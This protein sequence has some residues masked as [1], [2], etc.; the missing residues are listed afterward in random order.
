[1]I[2]LKKLWRQ[3]IVKKWEYQPVFLLSSFIITTLIGILGCIITYSNFGNSGVFGMI[4][5]QLLVAPLGGGILYGVIIY[6]FLGSILG[7][8][9]LDSG[10]GGVGYAHAFGNIALI[11]IINIHGY[12]EVVPQYIDR[13][14]VAG[15]S[16][17]LLG[18]VLLTYV[19]NSAVDAYDLAR[20]RRIEENNR[21]N[22]IKSE[23][24]NW[25]KD[26][27]QKIKNL[28]QTT[29]NSKHKLHEI[30][31]LIAIHNGDEKMKSFVI[32]KFS[33]YF[34]EIYVL[35]IQ[36]LSV[37]NFSVASIGLRILNQLQPNQTHSQ[38]IHLIENHK[39]LVDVMT[40]Q[41]LPPNH[42]YVRDWQ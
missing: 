42:K 22:R 27:E 30:R 20:Q 29:T 18:S 8:D 38:A 3:K 16:V 35:T 15:L 19:H 9:V 2:R 6:W 34:D 31:S 32:K 25:I 7:L 4:P 24:E 40:Q 21:Q 39:V 37:R 23:Y 10:W 26:T 13:W 41:G 12:D 17:A 1:M 28:F 33:S 5:V 11:I 14:L 36:A